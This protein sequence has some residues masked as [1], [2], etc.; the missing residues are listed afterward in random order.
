MWEVEAIMVVI[1]K[2]DTPMAQEVQNATYNNSS[3]HGMYF[4][5]FKAYFCS[6]GP[7]QVESGR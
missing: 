3:T 7:F 4:H 1:R 6:P 5:M 2:L